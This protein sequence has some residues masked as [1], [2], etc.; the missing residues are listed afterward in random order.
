VE[1]GAVG[2]RS[3]QRKNVATT[4]YTDDEGNVLTLRHTD[5]KVPD[6][7]VGAASSVDDQW[8]RRNEIRFERHAVRW[9]ISGLVYEK[10]KELLARYRMADSA[11]QEWV[12]RT[13]DSHLEAA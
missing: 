11:T 3:R 10:Q 13:I 7:H 8:H 5:A 2:K 12:Q 6:P 4:D 9:E 1:T